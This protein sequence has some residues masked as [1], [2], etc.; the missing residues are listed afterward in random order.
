VYDWYWAIANKAITEQRDREVQFYRRTLEG[1]KKGAVIFDIGANAGYMVDIFLRL[2]AKVLAV[3]PDAH[4]QRILTQSFLRYRVRRKPVTVVGKAVGDR[5]GKQTMWVDEPG[6]AKNTLNPKWVETLR[7]DP[8]RFGKLLS[9][10]QSTPVDI[11]T[12]EELIR[13]HGRPFY[14]KI[15]VEGNEASVIRGLQSAVP[16]ISFEVNLPEFRME[17]LQCVQMLEAIAGGG[18][19]NYVVDCA[20]GMAL[21]RWLPSDAFAGALEG[22]QESCVEVFW[23]AAQVSVHQA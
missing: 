19:L 11:V 1:L 20:A 5:A 21:D 14:I 8:G 15:D 17:G 18:R 3:E 22:C 13:L 6:S 10:A 9:F 23:R 2:G 4:N 7:I 12:L 16:Y